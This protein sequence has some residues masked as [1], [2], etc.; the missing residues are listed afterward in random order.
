MAAIS[1]WSIFCRPISLWGMFILN[2]GFHMLYPA[3]SG[4]HITLVIC[5]GG[6]NEPSV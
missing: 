1:T 2:N 3:L 6:I 5:L 4:S